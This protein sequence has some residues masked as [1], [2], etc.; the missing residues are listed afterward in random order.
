MQKCLTYGNCIVLFI[1][2]QN[3]LDSSR[4][5]SLDWNMFGIT[6]DDLAPLNL[7]VRAPKKNWSP[8]KNNQVNL[9]NFS[10]Q[11]LIFKI[12]VN[13]LIQQADFL[14]FRID[15]WSY[16]IYENL[17]NS[18]RGEESIERIAHNQNTS[19]SE[20]F[21]EVSP[22]HIFYG[23]FYFQLRAWPEIFIIDKVNGKVRLHTPFP[24]FILGNFS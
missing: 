1:N 9:F 10:F 20:V 16:R 2:T 6:E 21:R 22:A 4:T 17:L 3:T 7:F 24:F 11:C 23:Q 8:N 14:D 19:I 5:F 13:P 15:T 12:E 18:L